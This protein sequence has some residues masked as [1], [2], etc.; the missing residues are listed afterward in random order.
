[1]RA[2]LDMVRNKSDRPHD[3]LHS[4]DGPVLQEPELDYL[5]QRY[6]EHFEEALRAAL[7]SAAPRDRAILRLHLGERL[8]ID[9]LAALYDV[10]RSTAHRWLGEARERLM[11]STRA[12]LCRRLDVTPSEYESLAALVRSEVAVSV[13]RLLEEGAAAQAS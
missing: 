4:S 8:S 6:R 2:A 10:G 12:E 7:A 9:K 1:M 13:V 11:E 5:R 3:T